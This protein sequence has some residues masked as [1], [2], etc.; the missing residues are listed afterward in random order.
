MGNQ[1]GHTLGYES[2]EE[3]LREGRGH[4]LGCRPAE[5]MECY[6]AVIDLTAGGGAPRVRA[7]ALRR[8]AVLHHL[9]AEPQIARDLCRRSREVAVEANADDLAADASNALAGFALERGDLVEAERQYGDALELAGGNPFLVGKIE[10]N[11]GIVANIRGAWTLAL[12]HYCRSLTAYE[13]AADERGCALAHHNLGMIHADQKQWVEA[14]RHYR[15]SQALAVAAGDR[16]LG[17]IATMNLAEVHLAEGELDKAQTGAEEALE[18]FTQVEA[19]RHK[20]GAHRLLG[21]I[22]RER[23]QIALAESHLRSA[24]EIAAN[25]C[26]P[27][28]QADAA[29]ELA[30]LYQAGGKTVEALDLLLLAHELY[31]QLR[32]QADLADIEDR[33]ETIRK[34]RM[35]A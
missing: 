4:D 21:M 6:A 19:R 35:Q 3:L 26:A 13:R 5:A 9:R 18:I 32:A 25:S 8:L 24:L 10:Q 17:G 28:I 27:L 7:E 11:L 14:D 29:K 12:E 1:L 16:H 20:A 2:V 15:I 30:T 31:V 33:I 23:N 34:G 22:F